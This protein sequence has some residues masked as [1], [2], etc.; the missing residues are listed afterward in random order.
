MDKRKQKISKATMSRYPVYLKALRKMQHQGKEM[1]LSS[2][3]YEETGI[4]D[5]TIRRDFTYL[6]ENEVLGR[7]GKGYDV[8]KLIDVITYVPELWSCI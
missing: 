6:S 3:L 4:Q 2:E 7:R 5:T 8:K 1:F